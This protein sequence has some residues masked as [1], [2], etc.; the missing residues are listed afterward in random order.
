MLRQ[1][2]ECAELGERHDPAWVLAFREARELVALADGLQEQLLL[3]LR[4]LPDR[5][6]RLNG[7]R[8]DV[9]FEPRAL[10][11]L[12][13]AVAGESGGDCGGGS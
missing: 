2:V 8:R 6:V 11:H 5:P 9:E 4:R 10:H 12:F 1:L 3:H 13:D 7:A